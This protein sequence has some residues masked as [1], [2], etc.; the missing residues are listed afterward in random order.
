MNFNLTKFGVHTRSTRPNLDGNVARVF[1]LID[2]HNIRRD[3]EFKSDG[4]VINSLPNLDQKVP[5]HSATFGVL[6]LRSQ[7]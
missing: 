3:H 7:R 4:L 1:A 6:V 2:G 5:A